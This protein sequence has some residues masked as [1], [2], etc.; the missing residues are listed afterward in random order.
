MIEIDARAL[1][2][3]EMRLGK[4]RSKAPMVISR[5]LNRATTNMKT[6]ISR[7]AREIYIVKSKDINQALTL[8]RANKARL[9]AVLRYQGERM[10]LDK[11]K[12]TPKNPNPKKRRIVKVAVKKDGVKPLLHAFVA[13]IN[14]P[15]IFERVG[16]PRLPIRRLFGPAV[17]QMVGN[18]E[19]RQFVESEAVKTYQKR[20]NH[21]IKRVLEGGSL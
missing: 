3:V 9:S 18:E 14:G 6:N 13:N 1:K 19:L 8:K 5:A 12:Y 15:K 20:L 4:Y 17:P 16:K 2:Q 7:K 11:F 21:E 10:P